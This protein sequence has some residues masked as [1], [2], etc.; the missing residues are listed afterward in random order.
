MRYKIYVGVISTIAFFFIVMRPINIRTL[1]IDVFVS[2]FFG[3]CIYFVGFL[4]DKIIPYLVK[5]VLRNK[6]EK[7]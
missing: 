6:D 3:L 7:Q 1:P 2:I 5:K 4:S